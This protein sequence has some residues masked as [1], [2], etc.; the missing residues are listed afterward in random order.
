MFTTNGSYLCFTS[1]VVLVTNSAREINEML[2][3]LNAWSKEVPKNTKVMQSS[4]KSKVNLRVD[5]FDLN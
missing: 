3:K 1:D 5:S 2:Q 4:D